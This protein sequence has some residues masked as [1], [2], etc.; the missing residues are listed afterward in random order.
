MT[1]DQLREATDAVARRVAEQYDPPHG[2]GP[3]VRKSKLDAPKRMSYVASFEG[4]GNIPF[5]MLRFDACWPL[6]Q[7]S[8]RK[9]LARRGDL[10]PRTPGRAEERP[11]R[12]AFASNKG[13][14]PT[15]WASFG[16]RIVT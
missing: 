9:T 7:E 6:T 4:T 3:G 15:R 5:D 2:N 13:F 12:V 8:V 1:P 11:R 16:W 14:T 10:G